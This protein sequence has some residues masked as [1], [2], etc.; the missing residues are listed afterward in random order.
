MRKVKVKPL[1]S[2]SKVESVASPKLNN[3]P[4]PPSSFITKNVQIALVPNS[5]L[6]ERFI[7][8]KLIREYVVAFYEDFPTERRNRSTSCDIIGEFRTP[9]HLHLNSHQDPVKTVIVVPH[10]SQGKRLISASTTEIENPSY[11]KMVEEELLIALSLYDENEANEGAEKHQSESSV[12]QLPIPDYLV[13][14]CKATSIAS[15][16]TPNEKVTWDQVSMTIAIRSKPINSEIAKWLDVIA[17]LAVLFVLAT[18][19]QA[20]ADWVNEQ[21]QF[22]DRTLKERVEFVMSRHAPLG[23]KLNPQADFVLGNLVILVVDAWHKLTSY[24]A[25]YTKELLAIACASGAVINGGG[26]L[27]VLFAVAFDGFAILGTHVGILHRVISRILRFQL[28]LIGSLALLMRGKKR[29][30][31][32]NRV[33]TLRTDSA[34]L[35][36]GTMAIFFFSFTLQTTLAYHILVLAIWSLI[37]L[38]QTTLFFICVVLRSLPLDDIL[39]AL[40]DWGTAG[41]DGAHRPTSFVLNFD[42]VANIWRLEVVPVGIGGVISEWLEFA[43]GL[44]A[45]AWARRWGSQKVLLNVLFG[46]ELPTVPP[47]AF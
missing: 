17:G 29:N 25:V 20:L 4:P 8:G 15:S 26:G 24:P 19:W 27:S 28:G 46:H 34:Q 11:G 47:P 31:L 5:L 43:F 38:V 41:S 35:M 7:K 6:K 32:R 18:N 10:V 21:L 3:M 37:F 45:K 30:V 2:E 1:A 13:Q 16:G 23:F 12:T 42:E 14:F 9:S 36:L 44:W 22:E 39:I 40:S 33:D